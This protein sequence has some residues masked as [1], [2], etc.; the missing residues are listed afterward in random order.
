MVEALVGCG[1][2]TSKHGDLAH[3]IPKPFAGAF[4]GWAVKPATPARRRVE[5]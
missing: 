3:P 4:S 2:G 5:A 1:L